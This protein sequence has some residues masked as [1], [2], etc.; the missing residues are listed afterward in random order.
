MC[1]VHGLG[2]ARA[3]AIE[4]E[5]C[6]DSWTLRGRRIRVDRLE[7]RSRGEAMDGRHGDLQ[8]PGDLL[9][10]DTLLSQIPQPSHLRQSEVSPNTSGPRIGTADLQDRRKMLPQLPLSLV[11]FLPRQDR[12]V[13]KQF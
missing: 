10:R 4:A 5:M 12:V 8:R 7:L 2:R 9:R 3:F 11:K 13:V 6:G 1:L